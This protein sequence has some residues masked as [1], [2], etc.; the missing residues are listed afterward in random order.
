MIIERL[1]VAIRRRI[2]GRTPDVDPVNLL[3]QLPTEDVIS[4]GRL[5]AN[6]RRNRP[7]QDLGFKAKGAWEALTEARKAQERQQDQDYSEI[8]DQAQ[9]QHGYAFTRELDADAKK[10]KYIRYAKNTAW[11]LTIV[12]PIME[13]LIVVLDEL[14][15]QA[16]DSEAINRAF[17]ES[18]IRA[19][20]EAQQS[21]SYKIHMQQEL[22]SYKKD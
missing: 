8:I 4:S 19:I 17:R 18:E 16:R 15:K 2:P 1:S 10:A 9:L 5:I 13:G 7:D 12:G 21:P 20:R 14:Q 3:A 22:D 11:A 6:I